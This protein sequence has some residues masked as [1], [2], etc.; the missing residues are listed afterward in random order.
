MGDEPGTSRVR[1]V[2]CHSLGSSLRFKMFWCW[3][4]RVSREPEMAGFHPG[5]LIALAPRSLPTLGVARVSVV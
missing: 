3:R 2:D 5:V 4:C 1:G